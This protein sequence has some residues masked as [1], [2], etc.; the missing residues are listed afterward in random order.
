MKFAEGLSAVNWR[1]RMNNEDKLA[2]CMLSWHFLM[3]SADLYYKSKGFV[4]NKETGNLGSKRCQALAI[5][6]VQPLLYRLNKSI[7]G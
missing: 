1:W 2:L 6:T 5:W 3:V 4:L 7:Y